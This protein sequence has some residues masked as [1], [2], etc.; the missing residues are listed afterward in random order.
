MAGAILLLSAGVLAGAVVFGGGDGSD[1]A[2][3]TDALAGEDYPGASE[4]VLPMSSDEVALLI[5]ADDNMLSQL[6]ETFEASG[7]GSE[8]EVGCVDTD[9]G[10]RRFQCVAE[11]VQA[12]GYGSQTLYTFDVICEAPGKCQWT[13]YGG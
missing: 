1:A 4:V 10:G 3:T 8:I 13:R 2:S 11:A 7:S 6:I 9:G 12:G 5:S